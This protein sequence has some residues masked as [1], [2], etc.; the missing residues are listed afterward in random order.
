MNKAGVTDDEAYFLTDK[1]R[2]SASQILPISHFTIMTSENIQELLPPGKDLAK[3]TDATCE[4][5]LG[6][7]IGA[8]YII[9]GEIIRY[10]GKLRVQI[11]VHHVPSGHFIG[12]EDTKAGALE[13]QESMLAEISSVLM[14]KV[15]AHAGVGASAQPGGGAVFVP[16]SQPSSPSS[17]AEVRALAPSEQ[18]P[19]TATGPAGLYITSNPPGAEVYLGQ[20]KAGTTNPAFQKVN[21]QPG[22]TVRVV[23]LKMDL[24]HDA[25]F[26]VALKSGVMKFEGVELKPAFGALKIESDPS[27]ADVYIGGEKVGS[28]PYNN[29][30]YPS[31]Q[32]LISLKKEMY[33][34][35]EDQ[36][37]SV[38]DGQETSK[39]FTLSQDFGTLGSSVQ[40]Q[41]RRGDP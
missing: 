23:T 11:K 31:G 14:N 26:D 18:P 8:E 38:S 33:L 41:R 20:T 36:Q 2:R 34:P 1:V 7:E 27:G 30:R 12:S 9:T 39:M 3:C 28:T 40:S 4:V 13:E 5:E 32:Y 29:P 25:S 15:L 37:I 19:A 24:Y 6:R 35:K 21:L 10:A 22:T 17:A 16:S